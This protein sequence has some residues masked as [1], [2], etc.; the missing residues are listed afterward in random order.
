MMATHMPPRRAGSSSTGFQR[1]SVETKLTTPFVTATKVDPSGA[2]ISVAGY[3]CP[4]VPSEKSATLDGSIGNTYDQ[5]M[6]V[7][8]GVSVIVMVGVKVGNA[9]GVSAPVGDG[10]GLGV[11]FRNDGKSVGA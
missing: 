10:I 3:P 5:T 1:S 11:Y 4:A 9:S 2:N 6:G 7:M 8:V